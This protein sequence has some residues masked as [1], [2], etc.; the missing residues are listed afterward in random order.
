MGR[1]QTIK[2]YKL[3]EKCHVLTS[4]QNDAYMYSSTKIYSRIYR[5]CHQTN[6][7]YRPGQKVMIFTEKWIDFINVSLILDSFFNLFYY[8]IRSKNIYMFFLLFSPDGYSKIIRGR[9]LQ[10]NHVS[11]FLLKIFLYTVSF[12]SQLMFDVTQA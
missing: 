10:W 6:T 3:P 9:Q 12:M 5:W 1:M 8:R 2:V 7:L 4:R 11:T